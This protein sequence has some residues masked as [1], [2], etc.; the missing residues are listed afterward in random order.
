[1]TGKERVIAAI[2]HRE[3]DRVPT[4]ENQVDGALVEQILGRST[5][6]NRGWDELQAL[7]GGRRDEVV[8]DYCS[9]HVDLPEAL[10]WD[11]VRVPVVPAAGPHPRPEMTGPYSWKD[12][13]GL[14]VTF[15]PEAG[16]IAVR[17]E[18]P[19]LGIDD[20]PDPD[21]PF[22][23]DPS[24]LEAIRHVV[25]HLGDTHFVVARL[26]VDGTFPWSMT[27]GMGELL[28]RMIT[29][30]EFVHRAVEVYVGRSIAYID[31]VLDA[32]AHAV[33]ATDDYSDNRGPLMGKDRFNEFVLPGLVRQCEA[34]HRRGAYFI[35]HTDGSVWD[36]LDSF[37]EIGVDGWH[38]IQPHIGM[39]MRLLK[40]RYGDRLCLFGGV[41]CETL[42][43]APASRARDEVRY[44]IEHAAKGGGLIV[45][46][47][48]VLQPGTQLENYRAMRQA[49]RDHGTYPITTS[50]D[51]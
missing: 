49:V 2:E 18:F 46:T 43:A 41:N 22:T 28:V 44:A 45:T 27:V 1:M 3:P 17:H 23:V 5:L 35:K 36:I 40:E 10:E 19:E 50:S 47:S 26:P 24:E 51:S 15:N 31:A 33:M 8:A 32:G 16:N 11:F 42:I 20:L 9:A 38:G 34:I 14:Q 25:K 21:D 12:E 39:D 48:N 30:P 6:Y 37:V 13:R 7:W 4:G 29:D